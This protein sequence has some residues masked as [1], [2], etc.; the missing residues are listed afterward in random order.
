[1]EALSLPVSQ[2]VPELISQQVLALDFSETFFHFRG[3]KATGAALMVLVES[4]LACSGVADVFVLGVPLVYFSEVSEVSPRRPA[5]ARVC[6]QLSNS[7][8]PAPPGIRGTRPRAPDP[9]PP[10]DLEGGGAV[11]TAAPEPSSFGTKRPGRVARIPKPRIGLGA[12][13]A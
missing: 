13:W 6:H 1:M 12:R 10:A 8:C 9:V 3:Q 5:A 4:L 7:K 2:R 11:G